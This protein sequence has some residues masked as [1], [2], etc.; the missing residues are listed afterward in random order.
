MK[1]VMVP[2]LAGVMVAIFAFSGC[3]QQATPAPASEP[4]TTP[5][6]PTTPTPA[7]A[8]PEVL[9][10]QPAEFPQ[11]NPYWGLGFRPDGTQYQFAV[12][13]GWLSEA[14]QSTLSDVMIGH[15]KYT[16]AHVDGYN[17]NS[18]LENQI[19]TFEDL[20]T[21]KVDGIMCMPLDSSGMQPVGEKAAA[22]GIP[23]CTAD[24]TIRGD[25][26]VSNVSYDQVK[27]GELGAEIMLRV[28]QKMNKHLTVY[29]LRCPQAAQTCYERYVGWTN[30]IPEGVE[31]EWISVILA[32]DC[33]AMDE[34]AMIALMD[35]MPA[36]PEIN[37]VFSGGGMY[38]GII[39][40]LKNLGRYYPIGDPNHVV[41]VGNEEFP[42][43]CEAL[44]GGYMD[45]LATNSCYAVADGGVKQMLWTV[46][47]GQT[48]P[49]TVLLPML[50]V[51]QD[52]V[53]IS[54]FGA[55]GR[56]GDM[57]GIEPNPQIWP[58]LDMTDYGIM[59]PTY[60]P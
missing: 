42:S 39:Q 28:A 14:Y 20:I 29:H 21:R 47:L 34:P 2:L 58:V 5:T 57:L 11:P 36:H 9:P 38:D 37:A 31:N 30:V 56:W 7:P 12:S 52:N 51:N 35:A 24:N 4:P 27:K 50:E 49:K 33:E 32:P 1:K 55:P 45:G 25:S 17:A 43:V 53:D 23:V 18:K 40:G 8:A 54:P 15:L 3:A 46:C 48:V 19:A 22:A 41:Y 26:V 13:M 6:T 44:R 16:G 59:T 10:E 60:Q